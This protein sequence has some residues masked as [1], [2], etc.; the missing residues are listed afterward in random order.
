[1]VSL[2]YGFGLGWASPN[3]PLLLSDESPLTT[4]PVSLSESSWISSLFCL[5]GAFGSVTF[6]WLLDTIGRKWAI[7]AIGVP[8]AIS[9]ALIAFVPNVSSLLV[10]RFLIGLS[11]GAMLVGV[12]VFV[13][14]IA[15][16]R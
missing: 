7:T 10:A 16:D 8:E 9:W 5:G 15:N 6:G 12:P 2:I 13:S 14:E 4:G 11:G 3:V 1:M